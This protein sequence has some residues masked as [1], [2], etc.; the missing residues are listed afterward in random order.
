MA[1]KRPLLVAIIFGIIAVA[2]VYVYIKAKEKEIGAHQTEYGK[3]VVA[4]DNIPV[5]E[6]IKEGM[7]REEDWPVDKI[8]K[9][10]YKEADEVLGK[11][12]SE[13]IYPGL[14]LLPGQFTEVSKVEAL[15]FRLP[16]QERGVTIGVT[17]VAS[18]G[19]N[20]M[21][22]DNVD[23]VAT[24]KDNK[25][26]GEATSITIL[27]DVQVVAVGKDIGTSIQESEGPTIPKTV[28][29]AVTPQE[30]E[31]LVL[32]DEAGV[33]RLSLRPKDEKFAPPSSGTSISDLVAYNPTH[34]DEIDASQRAAE[35]KARERDFMLKMMDK[36]G[37]QKPVVTEQ[38]VK[39]PPPETQPEGP[40]V[41]T[42]EVIIGGKA[43]Q[44]TVPKDDDDPEGY[45]VWPS[46]Y[47]ILYGD[48]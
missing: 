20:V 34:Q 13:N 29:L 46:A 15:A 4:N 47:R 39:L 24:F 30:A 37:G 18:V 48:K 14:P 23:V 35:D 45:S 42:I 16:A 41:V 27:R 11:V 3:V 1:S 10:A 36:T 38:G 21:P 8:P 32:A 28:T 43:E 12:T 25:E 7:V 22:N 5:R 26:V 17:E 9:D 33:I 6:T 44:V 31:K 40:E 19:G 2:L